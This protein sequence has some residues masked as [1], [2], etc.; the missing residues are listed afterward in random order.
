M[1]VREQPIWS[2]EVLYHL[3]GDRYIE[4][5]CQRPLELDDA[6]EVGHMPICPRAD[7]AILLDLLTR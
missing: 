2:V 7:P 3:G 1:G 6:V 4:P 5:A